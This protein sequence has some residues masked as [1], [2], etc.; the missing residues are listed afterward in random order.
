MRLFF[1]V[2]CVTVIENQPT[3]ILIKTKNASEYNL[4]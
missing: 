2:E 1:I 4:E 3:I